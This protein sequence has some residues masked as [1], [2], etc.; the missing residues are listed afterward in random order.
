LMLSKRISYFGSRTRAMWMSPDFVVDI[1]A[2]F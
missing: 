2:F 1:D